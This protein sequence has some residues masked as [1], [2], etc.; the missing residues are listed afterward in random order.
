MRVAAVVFC[1]K[2]PNSKSE[3]LHCCTW[4][5][6]V[7]SHNLTACLG[8]EEGGKVAW[9][10]CDSHNSI[11]IS[12]RRVDRRYTHCPSIHTS[13]RAHINTGAADHA[14]RATL[15]AL[16][17]LSC[18]RSIEHRQL[19]TSSFAYGSSKWSGMAR[20]S[21]SSCT[22]STIYGPQLH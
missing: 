2:V 7:G 3:D 17:D 4:S 15:Y 5:R 19:Y 20:A 13:A 6:F 12:T 1:V 8:V 22:T 18:M 21:I 9:V 10:A 11:G 14:W 16:S